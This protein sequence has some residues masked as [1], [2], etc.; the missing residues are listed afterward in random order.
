MSDD[1]NMKHLEDEALENVSG[2]CSE[3]KITTDCYY[4]GDKHVLT[5]STDLKIIPHGLKKFYY[6]ANRYFCTN[7]RRY[8]YTLQLPNGGTAILDD[9]MKIVK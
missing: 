8:F 9:N 4:C 1:K 3:Q 5:F 2:G 7:A 6:G